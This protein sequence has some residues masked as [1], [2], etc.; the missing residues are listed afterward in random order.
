MTATPGG[1]VKKTF[2]VL[3]QSYDAEMW[4]SR[5]SVQAPFFEKVR[6]SQDILCSLGGRRIGVLDGCGQS[7]NNGVKGLAS[8]G[9][10]STRGGAQGGAKCSHHELDEKTLPIVT[11]EMDQLGVVRR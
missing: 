11:R 4:S 6:A 8:H 9:S 1:K 10:W 3:S 7:A 5:S 2:M